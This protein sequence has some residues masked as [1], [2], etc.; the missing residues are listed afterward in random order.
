[1]S[2]DFTFTKENLDRCLS[3]LAKEFRKSNGTVEIILVGG[4]AVL[5]NYGFRDM[6]YNI[7][8]ILQAPSSMKDAI[9]KVGDE[10]RLPYG[11]LN[12]DFVRTS[13]YSPKLMQYSR[14]Y[15]RF[16]NVLEV[17]T[18]SGAYLVA[19]KL[20]SGRQYKNDISDVVGILEEQKAC[21]KPISLEMIQTAVQNL[22]GSW[23]KLPAESREFIDR[24]MKAGALEKLYAQ[25]RDME[26]AAKE[27][28]IDFEKKYP[29][30]A[31]TNNVNDIIRSLKRSK[32]VGGDN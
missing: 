14:Y 21:G 29:G 2:A 10:M 19:M 3:R 28:L 27:S 13:S 24:V 18:V 32:T 26:K 8:A 20:M 1:M 17:R 25:Y 7:D 30:A 11:W 31:N 6:T 16:G 23:E 5:A 22:Y 15:K 4:A 12:S 9:N